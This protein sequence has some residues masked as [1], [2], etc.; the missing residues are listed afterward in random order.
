MMKQESDATT[1]LEMVRSDRVRSTFTNPDR[2]AR[3]MKGTYQ[4]GILAGA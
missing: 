2:N 3:V 1:I 4:Q